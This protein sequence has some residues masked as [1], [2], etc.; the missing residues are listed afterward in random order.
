LIGREVH[1]E[2]ARDRQLPFSMRSIRTA[3]HLYIIN[4]TSDRTPMG[5]L[6]ALKKGPL[7]FEDLAGK[8]RLTYAD[9]DAGPT[10]AWMILNRD[11]PEF[12][13]HWD[14]GFGSRPAEELYELKSDPHQIKNLAADSKYG[15]V[16][17]RLRAQLMAELKEHNDP[18]LNGNQ[19]DYPP[20]CKV[21]LDK[22]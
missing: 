14:L 10:K 19:F 13:F 21:G 15:A 3:D 9:V 4:F 8:T 18:R 22:E 7:S 12:K 2:S 5:D 1:V 16:R 11:K 20:Y 6:L 17:A